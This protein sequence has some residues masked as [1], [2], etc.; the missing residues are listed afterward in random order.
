[1]PSYLVCAEDSLAYEFVESIIITF[2][3]TILKRC[4]IDISSNAG[5]LI[6]EARENSLFKNDVV[7]VEN[8]TKDSCDEIVNSTKFF[9]IDRLLVIKSKSTSSLSKKMID[10]FNEKNCAFLFDPVYDTYGNIN[11]NT[12]NYIEAWTKEIIKQKNIDIKEDDIIFIMTAHDY[13]IQKIKATL[14]KLQILGVPVT[15]NIL[16]EICQDDSSYSFFKFFDHLYSKNI[17]DAFMFVEAIDSKIEPV[18]FLCFILDKLHMHCLVSEYSDLHDPEKI[19]DKIVQD[20][21]DMSKDWKPP[22]QY[23]IKL[24]L[25][26]VKKMNRKTIFYLY[27]YVYSIYY[28]YRRGDMSKESLK[29]SLKNFIVSYCFTET[30]K[31]TI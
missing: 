4:Y 27:K 30:S 5:A 20:S 11:I 6:K 13:N 15:K 17:D 2:G 24:I 16:L 9:G 3:G 21:A 14:E 31:N 22:H 25:N 29:N 23:V 28:E 1:M 26:Q 19:V 10:F 12:F 7:I 8:V 18:P